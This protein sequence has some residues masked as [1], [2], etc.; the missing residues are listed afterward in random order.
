HVDEP[1]RAPGVHHLLLGDRRDALRADDPDRPVFL[2]L[3]RQRRELFQRRAR[4]GEV[5]D[6]VGLGAERA[7]GGAARSDRLLQRLVGSA[8]D[9]WVRRRSATGCPAL[10]PSF[11]A[12]LFGFF[13]FSSHLAAAGPSSNAALRPSQP[14]C[15]T[16]SSARSAV[17]AASLTTSRRDGDR[18][19][20]KT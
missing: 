19:P 2:E 17:I 16:P 8:D 11:S 18:P 13:I 1:G 4:L 9:S 6:D 7:D 3:L 20:L 15:R 12:R 10:M 14:T 5:E